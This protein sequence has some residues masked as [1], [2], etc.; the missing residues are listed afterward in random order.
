MHS[1]RV[2]GEERKGQ[3]VK[4]G[5]SASCRPSDRWSASP[6]AA[7]TLVPLTAQ[8]HKRA[9]THTHAH[10]IIIVSCHDDLKS[11]KNES[12]PFEQSNGAKSWQC[13]Q[14]QSSVQGLSGARPFEQEA[15][16]VVNG[17]VALNGANLPCGGGVKDAV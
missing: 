7:A 15:W 17:K 6:L 9:R 5:T 16:T 8:P 1:K 12:W 13:G 2:K 14:G 10:I 4:R 3:R 11:Q